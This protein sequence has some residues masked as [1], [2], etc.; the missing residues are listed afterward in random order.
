MSGVFFW[1]ILCLKFLT[2][3]FAINLR[4]INSLMLQATLSFNLLG[5]FT[6][7]Q[8]LFAEPATMQILPK[9]LWIVAFDAGGLAVS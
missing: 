6:Y 3:Q 1:K 5:Q 8:Y 7:S 4:Y 2:L 9:R